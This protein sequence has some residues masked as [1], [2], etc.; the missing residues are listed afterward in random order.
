M[1]QRVETRVS[2]PE[3]DHRNDFAASFGAGGAVTSSEPIRVDP[4]LFVQ[5]GRESCVRL[6]A[7]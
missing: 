1:L 3:L 7:L 4:A 5:F 2:T 6:K